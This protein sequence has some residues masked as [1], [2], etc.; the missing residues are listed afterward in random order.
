MNLQ[1]NKKHFSSFSKSFQLPEMVSDLRVHLYFTEHK[2]SVSQTLILVSSALFSIIS[3]FSSKKI[4]SPF[5]ASS[6]LKTESGS[7]NCKVKKENLSKILKRAF[8]IKRLFRNMECSKTM[9]RSLTW[10]W[11][12][13]KQGRVFTAL[14]K[15]ISRI[16]LKSLMILS[17]NQWPV[18]LKLC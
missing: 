16:R 4:M 8:L 9:E 17:L 12:G 6:H 14:E 7:Q 13:W 10:S 1:W 2:L 5:L 3:K 15:S 11:K 18:M